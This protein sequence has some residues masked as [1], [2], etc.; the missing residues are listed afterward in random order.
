MEISDFVVLST[1]L[2]E[3]N[4]AVSDTKLKLNKQLYIVFGYW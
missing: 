2:F 1:P 3:K 4:R